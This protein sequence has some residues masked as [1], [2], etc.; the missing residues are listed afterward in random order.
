[1]KNLWRILF[2]EFFLCFVAFI[3]LKPMYAGDTKKRCK[4]KVILKDKTRIYGQIISASESKIDIQTEYG[5]TSVEQEM[6]KEIIYLGPRKWF[7]ALETGF[8]VPAMK[9]Y[10]EYIVST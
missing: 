10:N 2:L 5:Q 6:I 9:D 1:M 7:S 8:Y 4:V 3:S